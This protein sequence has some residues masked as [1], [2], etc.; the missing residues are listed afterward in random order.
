MYYYW[1]SYGESNPAYQDENLVSWPID[2]SCINNLVPQGRLELPRLS[3]L[4]PKTSVSTIPPPGQ[5][6]TYHI[7]IH[8]A[9]F[10]VYQ[11]Y[12]T[13]MYFNMESTVSRVRTYINARIEG[14]SCQLEDHGFLGSWLPNMGEGNYSSLPYWNTLEFTLTEGE[15]LTVCPQPIRTNVLQYEPHR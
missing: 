1:Y 15:Y 2:D 11:I 7:E 8:S 6:I 10:L 5:Y 3:S 12:T 9:R 14:F 4:V 13:R